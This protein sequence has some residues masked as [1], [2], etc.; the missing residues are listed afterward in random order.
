MQ[1]YFLLVS[2]KDVLRTDRTHPYYKGDNNPN[3]STL[4]DI[5]MTYCMYN[6]D[7]GA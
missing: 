3:I 5:L 7:L 6:F 1:F 2:D 4:Y